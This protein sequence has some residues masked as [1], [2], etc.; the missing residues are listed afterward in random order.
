[1]LVVLVSAAAGAFLALRR[2]AVFALAPVVAFFAA[3]A[4]V[5]GI[6]TGHDPRIIGV[7]IL[8]SI[9]APR[10]RLRRSLAC[11]GVS[12][13]KAEGASAEARGAGFALRGRTLCAAGNK[14]RGRQC[15][16]RARLSTSARYW[17][18]HDKAVRFLCGCNWP[19]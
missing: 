10:Y 5:T 8:G 6:A 4:M 7:E 13:Q 17:H 11:S 19:I 3:A 9:A 12:C 2:Y 15:S 1:M 16:D 14:L 18:H